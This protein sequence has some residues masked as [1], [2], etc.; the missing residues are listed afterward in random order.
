M[1]GDPAG[2]GVSYEE[3]VEAARSS[4]WCCLSCG[5]P[6]TFPE[7]CYD[8]DNARVQ[9]LISVS[10][11]MRLALADHGLPHTQWNAVGTQ[12]RGW[13]GA[14]PTQQNGPWF[15]PPIHALLTGIINT[16]KKASVDVDKGT[17]NMTNSTSLNPTT[18]MMCQGCKSVYEK[19]L[20][21]NPVKN[22]EGLLKNAPNSTVYISRLCIFHA[23]IASIL[24]TARFRKPGGTVVGENE[25]WRLE[26]LARLHLGRMIYGL[27]ELC[28]ENLESFETW[29]MCIFHPLVEWEHVVLKGGAL[30]K[31]N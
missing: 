21:D 14:P 10:R 28:N 20:D 5:M 9:A 27:T 8:I 29:Y 1:M 17:K 15:F 23:A 25:A 24:C 4:M 16:V 13:E 3:S 12:L 26:C 22:M 30:S 18:V 6:F 7:E 2:R 19:C 11:G 31:V